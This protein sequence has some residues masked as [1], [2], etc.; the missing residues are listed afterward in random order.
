M[1]T[2][3]SPACAE[4]MPAG[5]LRRLG[6]IISDT[7]VVVGL[8][9]LATLPFVPL[10][11]QLNAKAMLPSEVGWGW[12]LIYWSWLVLVW[13]GFFVYFWA[14][15]GQTIGMRAWRICIQDE[16][17]RKLSRAY[18]LQRLLLAALPW[19]PALIVLA[20]AE[21]MH[22]T[23]LQKVGEGLLLVGVGAL[24]SMCVDVQKRTWH[25]RLS[26]SCVILLP[27]L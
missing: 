18:A 15:S 23:V 25:D 3:E 6:A 4:Y 26:K 8:L 11:N 19:V 17:G 22:S 7:L 12:C 24:L 9:L 13:G 21:R 2:A 10:L 1:N 20:M 27:K 5:L 16:T 14:R